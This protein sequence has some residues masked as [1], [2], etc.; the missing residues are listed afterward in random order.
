MKTYEEYLKLLISCCRSFDR[1]AEEACRHRWDSIGKPIDGLGLLE[2]M[3][4]RIAGM[5]GDPEVRLRK[6]AVAVMCGDHGVVA[7]GVTQTGQEITALVAENIAAGTSSVCLMA[8]VAG[9]DVFAA[10]IGIA[11]EYGNKWKITP[12]ESVLKKML[13]AGD[14]DFCLPPSGRLATGRIAGKKVAAG[15]GHL[16][17]EPAMTSEPAALAVCRGIEAAAELKEQGYDIIVTG[18]MGIGNTTP[19]SAAACCL[20]G[21]KPEEATGRGAGLTREGLKRKISV[22]KRALE[23]HRPDPED[24]LDVLSK[25]GGFDLAGMTGLFLGGALCGIPVVIDGVISAASAALACRLNPG[26]RDFMLASHQGKEPAMEQLLKITGQEPVI[27]AGLALGEGTGGTA[28]LPLLD[29]ALAVYGENVTFEDIRMDAYER[30][31]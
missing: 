12:E 24:A 20:C 21:M 13:P 28:L 3:T 18:E 27:R 15:T 7:E 14:G 31:E 4:A 10:D 29:M 11:C 2:V 30:M 25:V 9:A 6:K 26:C 22:V 5:T 1:K 8:Q 16:S 23:I 17:R 19:A